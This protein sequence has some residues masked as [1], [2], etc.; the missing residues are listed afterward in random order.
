MREHSSLCAI[1]AH[2]GK[3]FH[4]FAKK[5]RSYLDDTRRR[6]ARVAR[7]RVT[8]ARMHAVALARPPTH[9]CTHTGESTET[10]SRTHA[11][12]PVYIVRNN[13]EFAQTGI[14]TFFKQGEQGQTAVYGRM[15]KHTQPRITHRTTSLL[16]MRIACLCTP[17]KP[18]NRGTAYTH[19]FA[20]ST[21]TD[22]ASS[23]L[24]P[25][26]LSTITLAQQAP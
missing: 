2:G 1:G 12:Y 3:R 17:P 23:P 5:I 10:H 4:R 20:H 6:Q 8:I 22:E 25:R 7:T 19:P 24:P 16:D 18:V 21:L 9:T 11:L 13:E 15:D 14:P 26:K